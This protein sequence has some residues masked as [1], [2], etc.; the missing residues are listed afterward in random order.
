VVVVVG[1]KRALLNRKFPSLFLLLLCG[2]QFLLSACSELTAS[3]DWVSVNRVIDGDTLLLEDDRKVRLLGLD[4]PEMDWG[5]GLGECFAPEAAA[6]LDLLVAEAGGCIRL[7]TDKR[8]FDIYGRVLA[9]L[10]NRSGELLNEKLLREG[11]AVYVPESDA[12]RWND[13]LRQAGEEAETSLRGLWH[14]DACP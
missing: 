5:G 9:Y 6:Y 4:A 2:L 8:H 3:S 14:P 1:L 10:W 12:I 11:Y 7:E 13:R